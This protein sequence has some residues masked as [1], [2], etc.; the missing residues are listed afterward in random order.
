M[1]QHPWGS[2]KQ[3]LKV[4]VE[5]PMANVQDWTGSETLE[6]VHMR[7]LTRVWLSDPMDG[8]LPGSSVQGIPQ[9]GALEWVPF[10]PPGERPDPGTEPMSLV[11]PA[12]ASRFSTAV[13]LRSERL[14]VKLQKR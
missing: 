13:P 9:A 8:G 2:T 4:L 7:V 5:R 11:S 14:E 1:S 12:L 6:S 3:L 10:P